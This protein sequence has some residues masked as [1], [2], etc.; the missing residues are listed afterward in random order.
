[1]HRRTFYLLLLGT[2]VLTCT[3][4]FQQDALKNTGLRREYIV[5]STTTAAATAAV[6]RAGGTV[7][8]SLNIIDGVSATLDSLAYQRLSHL[9]QIALH[10]NT[11]VQATSEST[12]RDEHEKFTKGYELYPAAAVN[13]QALHDQNTLIPATSCT[14]QGVVRSGGTIS[15]G[16]QGAGIT[17]AVVDS[18]LLPMQHASD[19]T[20]QGQDGTL[21]ASHAG[22]CIV[23]HDFLQ[24]GAPASSGDGSK[25]NSA[26]LH[27]HGTHVISTIADNRSVEMA[28]NA[29]PS[30]VGVAPQVNLMVARVLDQDG[31]GSYADVI[32]G[33]GWV[34][35]NK[36]RFNVRVLNLSLY[37]PVGGPYWADPMNQAVMRAWQAGIVVV[38]AA[39]NEGPEAG[40]ITAPGNVPYV[41]TV[42][43]LTNGRYTTSGYDE[44]ARYSSRGPTESAFVKP[45]ILVPA[46][47]TIAPLPKQSTLAKA[48]PDARIKENGDVDYQIGTP[49]NHKYY[50]LSGTSM[51]SAL[52][53][54][55]VALMLQAHPELTNDQV[56]YRLMATA[57]PAIDTATGQLVYSV[58]EQGAGMVDTPQAVNASVSPDRAN[59]GMNIALDLQT[60]D[61]GRDETHYWGTTTWNNDTGEFQL[62]A[63]DTGEML[64][65]WDGGLKAWSGGLK[66]WSGGLKAWSGGLKAWSGGLKAWSGGLKAWSGGLKAWSGST[67]PW[68]ETTGFPS[69]AASSKT[70]VLTGKKE[71]DLLP[72]DAGSSG[73]YRMLL[74]LLAR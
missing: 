30:P 26:D 3:P 27:G 73:M 74:P 67:R 14:P 15:E 41:V 40:T 38:A 12:E 11:A 48:F 29:P 72:L 35:A 16:L 18:G 63:P 61:D 1:M 34:V 19:W 4:L 68:T 6:L 33:I 65:V 10:A 23:Y 64:A 22:R 2:L 58:W 43:A 17:V 51:A 37:A 54:G 5:Q 36:D 56:K 46:T 9:P 59:E 24:T 32:A 69:S 55:I 21:F 70:D 25:P 44:L 53:S 39:G 28:P 42:G 57:I 49:S 13:A 66:A 7:Q 47:R 71:A 20:F 8:R 45:D 52:V 60:F 31:G 62:V 50:Y